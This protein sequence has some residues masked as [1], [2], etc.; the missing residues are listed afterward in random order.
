MNC[1]FDFNLLYPPIAAVEHGLGSHK[2]PESIEA[3]S[4]FEKEAA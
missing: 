2:L 1:N 3:E 4:E